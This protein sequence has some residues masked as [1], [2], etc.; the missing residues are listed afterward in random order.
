MRIIMLITFMHDHWNYEN[1]LYTLANDFGLEFKDCHYYI[2]G[3]RRVKLNLKSI[4]E[5]EKIEEYLKGY[6]KENNTS[7]YS[8]FK[9][10]VDFY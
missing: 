1:V 4:D 2:N 5:K 6:S 9:T 8:L 3:N 7:Y 10:C